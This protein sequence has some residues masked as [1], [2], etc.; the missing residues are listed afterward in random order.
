MNKMYAF[1]LLS[2]TLS[3][4][5]MEPVESKSLLVPSGLVPDEVVKSA[6]FNVNNEFAAGELVIVPFSSG[7]SKYCYAR[8]IELYTIDYPNRGRCYMLR[9]ATNLSRIGWGRSTVGKLGH[10]S[11]MNREILCAALPRPCVSSSESDSDKDDSAHEK[12]SNF[13]E[14][15]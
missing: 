13:N 3:L 5:A 2:I 6:S 10:R 4:T 7:S 15:D 14:P 8:A 12:K 11:S 9:V 1:G